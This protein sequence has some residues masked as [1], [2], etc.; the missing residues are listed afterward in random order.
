M[1]FNPMA[2]LTTE[3]LEGLAQAGHRYFVRQ[4]FARGA[5]PGI[6]SLI[7]THYKDYFRAKEH[8]DVLAQDASRRLYNWEDSTD[9][10]K[11]RIAAGQP[12]G[13]RIYANLFRR[14]WEKRL[15][16][17]LREKMR[18]YINHLDWEPKAGES[19][20]PQFYPHFGEVYVSLQYKGRE[21]RINFEEIENSG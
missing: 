12:Q 10:E 8:L 16:R 18:R 6:R 21:V 13:F 11:L 5:E 7:Y 3:V 4:S 14:D 2:L 19:I 9:R 15:S 1:T 17:M 20:E